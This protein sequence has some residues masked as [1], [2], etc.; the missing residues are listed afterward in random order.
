MNFHNQFTFYHFLLLSI[1]LLI[2][3]I[4]FLKFKKKP[5]KEFF[6]WKVL[7][8]SILFTF[9]GLFYS[10]FRRSGD[11]FIDSFGFPRGFFEYKELRK[12]N[13]FTFFTTQYF[14]IFYFSQNLIL[15]YLVS[16]LILK[17]FK[18]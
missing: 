11:W 5:L 9:L 3:N 16:N 10:E 18:K 13:G 8:F 2:I 12:S 15:F 4:L 1:I 7:L 14:N 17:F 6:S